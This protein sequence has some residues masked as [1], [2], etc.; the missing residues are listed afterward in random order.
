MDI[1]RTKESANPQKMD[2]KRHIANFYSGVF[3]RK[4]ML[5]F[6]TVYTIIGVL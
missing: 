2:I 5:P 3:L 1:K 6:S 4:Y